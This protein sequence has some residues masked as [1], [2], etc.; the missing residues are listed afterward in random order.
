MKKAD[1]I[2]KKGIIWIGLV[3]V[4]FLTVTSFFQ[5]C[6]FHWDETGTS[7][8]EFI[9]YEKKH[10]LLLMVLM[11]ILFLI[12]KKCQRWEKVSLKK[13]EIFLF[14]YTIVASIVWIIIADPVPVAD[15]MMVIQCAKEIAQGNYR[16]LYG[17]G[18]L[19]SFTH[20]LGIVFVLEKLYI[21]FG[22]QM[23]LAFRLGNVAALSMIYL[24]FIKIEELMEFSE[25]A[26][27]ISIICM[28]GFVVPIFY[29]TFIYGNMTGLA[30]SMWANYFLIKYLNDPK[31]KHAFIMVILAVIACV[32][33]TNYIIPMLAE[34]I[35]LFLNGIHKKR[36]INL[37]LCIV[38]LA[39]NMGTQ[40]GIEKY[41]EQRIGGRMAGASKM[42]WIAMA[43][44]EGPFASGWYNLSLGEMMNESYASGESQTEVAIKHLKNSAQQFQSG[45]R[46]VLGFYY[47][48]IVSQWN[49]PT[50]E[51]FWINYHQDGQ[52]N[53]T[54]SRVLQS[55]YKGKLNFLL[56][57]WMNWWHVIILL[58]STIGLWNIRK[59]STYEQCLMILIVIGGFFFHILWEAKSQYVWTYFILL[60]PFCAL[61][62]ERISE[63][64]K[65][66]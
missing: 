57:K 42:M 21:V 59:K 54:M 49:E 22:N 20:Q 34:V 11:I 53:G 1:G 51:A 25:K 37:L 45:E 52:Y 33:K 13:M 27:K 12:L 14:F 2:L 32:F 9:Y 31:W 4:G 16:S 63:K 36:W 19:Y 40:K 24:S 10:F 26:K 7:L 28:A 17:G 55:I 5:K 48:K 61:G 30:F 29:T 23:M 15:D 39:G 8:P 66:I 6:S 43:A 50:F 64:R 41:Y 44:E 46:N 62:M 18:Y 56:R 35:I 38:L 47:R 65:N 3:I 58:F 60:I